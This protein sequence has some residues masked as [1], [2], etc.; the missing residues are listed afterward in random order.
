MVG[1]TGRSVADCGIGAGIV[2]CGAAGDL[3]TL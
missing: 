3:A 2:G 1:F